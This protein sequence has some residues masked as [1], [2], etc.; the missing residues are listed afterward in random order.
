MS[1]YGCCW[2]SF[3]P[4][5]ST[6]LHGYAYMNL[7]FM[8]QS[9]KLLRLS[10]ASH[11]LVFDSY[12]VSARKDLPTVI[13]TS[14]NQASPY[15]KQALEDTQAPKRKS[16]HVWTEVT[17]AKSSSRTINTLECK[18]AAS[19]STQAVAMSRSDQSSGQSS[20]PNEDDWSSVID[21]AERRRIQNRIAQRKFR[22][23]FP[24]HVIATS[25]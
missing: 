25:T 10:S 18:R 9:A 16:F 6:T 15:Q 23:L 21:P 3:A 1:L 12:L 14:I 5:P 11:L 22:E 19:A 7:L 8:E 13:T 20:P 24:G 2:S 4:T 17:N